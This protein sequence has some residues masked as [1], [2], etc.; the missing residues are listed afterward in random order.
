MELP[1]NR[2]PQGPSPPASGERVSRKAGRVR[3]SRPRF[4]GP[5]ATV[6][7]SGKLPS[8][9]STVLFVTGTDTG[10]GKTVFTVALTRH[11]LQA[12]LEVAALKPFCSGGRSDAHAVHQTLGGELSL[13]EINPWHFRP[14]LAPG[15]AA[16]THPNPPGWKD[17]IRHIR[18]VARRHQITLV[19]GAGGLLSPL[20]VD[21]DAT[22]LIRGLG[23]TP[24][25]VCP[26]RLG[27]IGQTRLVLAAL[28]ET[29]RSEARVILMRQ[30]HPDSSAA[31]NLSYLQEL[32][33]MDRVVELPRLT[34]AELSG[35]TRLRRAV[36]RV[37]NTLLPESAL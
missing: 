1:T 2:P 30:A 28:P 7:N 12:G 22:Q 4:I 15:L 21:G 16:R 11:L 23:A 37:L 9:S 27:A 5:S 17:A 33:G 14:S 6:Q 24:I 26:N 34:P 13:D 32:F 35:R 29:S 20:T 8:G 18:L 31:S 36:R 25:V 3:G 10:V 19:E